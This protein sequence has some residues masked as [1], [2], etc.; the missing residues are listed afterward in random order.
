MVV[1]IV[2][3]D[4]EI[5]YDRWFAQHRLRHLTDPAVLVPRARLE[6]ESDEEG[7][8]EG[9]GEEGGGED[10]EEAKDDGGDEEDGGDVEDDEGGDE[11]VE[12]DVGG[13]DDAE[14]EV[15]DGDDAEGEVGGDDYWDMGDAAAMDGEWDPMDHTGGALV[16]VRVGPSQVEL[17]EVIRG[18]QIQLDWVV[19]ERDVV[20]GEWDVVIVER[21]AAIA[22]RN[23]AREERDGAMCQAEMA[24]HESQEFI[25][26]IRDENFHDMEMMMS[27]AHME[28]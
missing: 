9:D 6:V 11:D 24:V 12:D 19:I 28:L 7:G 5:A 21:D 10:S 17:M 1:D 15:G 3:A 27:R 18:L 4:T 13:D 16:P 2:D 20:I 14:G 25:S 22:E 23:V 26:S 8:D